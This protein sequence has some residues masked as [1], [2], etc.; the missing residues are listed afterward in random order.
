VIEGNLERL[1]LPELSD[2]T[3]L[4]LL[5]QASAVRL[6]QSANLAQR[7]LPPSTRP[8]T[9]GCFLAWRPSRPSP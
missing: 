4:E 3:A 1:D 8:K 7:W 2:V 5:N 6:Q 9:D